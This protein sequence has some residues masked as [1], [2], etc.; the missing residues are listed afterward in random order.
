MQARHNFRQHSVRHSIFKVTWYMFGRPTQLEKVTYAPWTSDKPDDIWS[1]QDNGVQLS[2]AWGNLANK[3]EWGNLYIHK[4]AVTSACCN[5]YTLSLWTGGYIELR[6]IEGAALPVIVTV[7][8]CVK[9]HTTWLLGLVPAWMWSS[10][11]EADPAIGWGWETL[12]LSTLTPV[13]TAANLPA[14]FGWL[15]HSYRHRYITHTSTWLNVTEY[16]N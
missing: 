15:S 11:V 4:R 10:L 9:S 3:G 2:P 8:C 14:A 7:K 6:S 1:G 13:S 16:E 5:M 12:S